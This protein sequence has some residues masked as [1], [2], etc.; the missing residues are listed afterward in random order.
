MPLFFQSLRSSSSGN[1]LL[2]RTDKT[3][4]LVDCGLGSMRQTRQVLSQAIKN[5]SQID[6]ILVTHLHSDHISYYPLRII[7]QEGIKLKVHKNC[8]DQLKSRHFRDELLNNLKIEYYE[9]EKFNIGDL[10]IQPFEIPHSPYFLTHGFAIHHEEKKIVIATDFR[11]PR[12]LYEYFID[13]D[14]IFVESNHD[15]QLLKKFPNPNSHYHLSNPKT[16]AFICDVIKKSKK[17][18]S[19]VMLGHLSNERNTPQ[20]AIKEIR[21]AFKNT[22]IDEN[23]KVT[24]AP[25]Y[26]LGEIITI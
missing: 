25:P 8:I 12:E 10:V 24:T 26:D 22:G 19:A 6:T 21:Q 16:A 18:P 4:I 1:C 14:F 17:Y 13:A 20:I 3:T 9:T 2:V 7:A 23:L 15:L 11:D 5:P